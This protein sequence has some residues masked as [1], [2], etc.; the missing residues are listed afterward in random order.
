[1]SFIFKYSALNIL[2]NFNVDTYLKESLFKL[3]S[4]ILDF[5]TYVIIVG[6]SRPLESTKVFDLYVFLCFTIKYVLLNTF[7]LLSFFFW[8]GGGE[9]R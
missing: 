8:G 1:M 6:S 7:C 9:P 5:I 4:M 2:Y 3:Y